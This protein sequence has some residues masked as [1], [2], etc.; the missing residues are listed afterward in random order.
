M[1]LSYS[2]SSFKWLWLFAILVACFHGQASY[3]QSREQVDVYYK[4]IAPLLRLNQ[5]SQ[6]LAKNLD[7]LT[8]TVRFS[9]STVSTEFDRDIDFGATH[10]R[11]VIN[12]NGIIFQ[13]DAV[14]RNGHIIAL[15]A[16]TT[17]LG[18]DSIKQKNVLLQSCDTAS[19][20]QFVANRNAFYQSRKT[21]PDF[22]VELQAN[23]LYALTC[24]DSS[25]KTSRY[26]QIEDLARH[27]Q[28]SILAE[29]LASIHCETQAYAVTGFDMIKSK[30][31]ILL[32]Q[33]LLIKHIKQ[34]NAVLVTCAG[35]L[36]GLK[37]TIY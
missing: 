24:G 36:A 23:E 11:T 3:G 16:A 29:W 15:A 37:R 6:T 7:S 27:N 35:C 32:Q 5:A 22:F 25:P 30:R 20:L 10:R 31:K 21:L 14:S 17:E 28:V 18:A 19:V 1:R 26:L 2:L 33:Q 8:T 4:P 34:R 9:R 13:L 12:A